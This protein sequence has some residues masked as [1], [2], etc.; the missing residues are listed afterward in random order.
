MTQ[1]SEHDT[2]MCR[3]ARQ[4]AGVGSGGKEMRVSHWKLIL[5]VAVCCLAFI[6]AA[7]AFQ[8]NWSLYKTE[9]QAPK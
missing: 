7:A 2:L 6:Q 4:N 3:P 5:I 8:V 9:D 1:T